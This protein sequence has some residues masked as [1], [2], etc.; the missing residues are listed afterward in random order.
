MTDNYSKALIYNKQEQ[1]AAL[2]EEQF[3]VFC[4]QNII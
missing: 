1:Q 3:A 4:N 2:D